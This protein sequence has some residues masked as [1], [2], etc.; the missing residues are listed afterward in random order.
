[1]NFSLGE[2]LYI[3]C[4]TKK[5]SG[6]MWL[7]AGVWKLKGIGKRIDK[8]IWQLCLGKEVAELTETVF[9]FWAIDLNPDEL[10]RI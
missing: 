8:R 4:C 10:F 6:I 3:E 7:L 9:F 5:K 1:M 2:R